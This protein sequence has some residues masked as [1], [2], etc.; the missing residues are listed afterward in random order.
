MAMQ[1]NNAV[2]AFALLLI[3]S[4]AVPPTADGQV[5]TAADVAG[6]NAEALEVVKAGMASPTKGDHARADRARALVMTTK[7]SDTS[8][9]IESSDPQIHGM[10]AEG[11]KDAAFQSAYRSCMRR[12]GF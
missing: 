3:V 10:E 9:A 11:A 1:Y 8:N 7:S 6:C 5:P 4:L 12:R 2:P